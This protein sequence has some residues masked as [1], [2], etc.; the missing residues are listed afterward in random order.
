[1]DNKPTPDAVVD[2]KGAMQDSPATAPAN[3]PSAPQSVMD[4]TPP[5]HDPVIA[6]EP[7]TAAEPMP[8]LAAEPVEPSQVAEAPAPAPAPA[9]TADQESSVSAEQTNIAPAVVTPTGAEQAPA[10]PVKAKKGGKGMMIAVAVILALV[11]ASAAVLYYLRTKDN[12]TTAKATTP[13]SQSTASTTPTTPTTVAK[14]PVTSTDVDTAS[15]NV[16]AS[17]SGLDENAD[18]GST[19]L[20]DKSL[21]LQ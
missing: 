1:M 16:D 13:S 18:F 8:S 19:A 4:V 17:I 12:K 21:G 14:T 7:A 20:S 11:L 15:K 6:S 2:D 5:P 10:A 9:P 3:Q